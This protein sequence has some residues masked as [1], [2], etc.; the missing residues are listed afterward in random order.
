MTGLHLVNAQDQR[1]DRLVDEAHA[2]LTELATLLTGD[3]LESQAWSAV[4]AA[5]ALRRPCVAEGI[6]RERLEHARS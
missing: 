1:R 6:D 5:K 3:P 4:L 2:V